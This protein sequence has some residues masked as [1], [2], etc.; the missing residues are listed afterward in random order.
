MA[1]ASSR[2]RSGSR[3]R[4]PSGTTNSTPYWPESDLDSLPGQAKKAFA[5]FRPLHVA[6][7]AAAVGAPGAEV[8]LQ[9]EVDSSTAMAFASILTC[10]VILGKG[11]PRPTAQLWEMDWQALGTDLEPSEAFATSL[12]K[13]AVRL[14]KGGQIEENVAKALWREMNRLPDVWSAAEATS[15]SSEANSGHALGFGPDSLPGL[16]KLRIC[17]RAI[18]A[19]AAPKGGSS[20]G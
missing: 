4:G 16:E 20:E 19:L 9:Y 18:A 17:I 10:A 13:V 1:A 6:E 5:G 14:S 11:Q 3:T 2:D 15:R 7:V 12:F 8:A